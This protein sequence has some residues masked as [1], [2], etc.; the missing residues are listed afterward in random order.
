MKIEFTKEELNIIQ[1][2]LQNR[3]EFEAL[4]KSDNVGHIVSAL[5]KIRSLFTPEPK[6]R[7]RA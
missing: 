7:E 4:R 2:A 6:K 5:Q 1:R 3:L